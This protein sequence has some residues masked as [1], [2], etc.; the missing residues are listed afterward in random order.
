MSTPVTVVRTGLANLASI[1]A[2]L[3]RC[4]AAVT[5]S[6]EPQT[7][8]AA[9]RLVLPGVGAFGAA[10]ALIERTGLR[11][12]LRERLSD[13]RPVLA[14]CLGMQ[15]LGEGSE[16]S[17]DIAGLGVMGTV[18]RRFAGGVR[19][20]QLGWNLVRVE[21]SGLLEEGWAYFANSYR[22]TEPPPGWRSATAE[23]GGPFVAAVERGTQLACQFHPELSGRW[24]SRLLE[25]WLAC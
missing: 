18:A 5:V 7:V 3:E 12:V 11:E 22:W 24:G 20:P 10:M 25:R 2:G 9:D 21:G 16:E 4:G 14:V 23:H 1:A 19:V 6:A 15:L 8:A 13:D 17:P